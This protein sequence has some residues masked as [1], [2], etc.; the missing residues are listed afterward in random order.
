MNGIFSPSLELINLCD[1]SVHHLDFLLL[2]HC[3]CTLRQWSRGTLHWSRGSHGP[4]TV[5]AR[6]PHAIRLLVIFGIVFY[7]PACGPR[8]SMA[9]RH[10]LRQIAE[11]TPADHIWSCICMTDYGEKGGGV[12]GE[13]KHWNQ[14]FLLLSVI[15]CFKMERFLKYRKTVWVEEL[16]FLSINDYPTRQRT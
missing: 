3:Y 13:G 2:M 15:C 7:A 4:M 1:C 6:E 11:G 16:K 8:G 12:K 5:K 9:L 10:L 14:F